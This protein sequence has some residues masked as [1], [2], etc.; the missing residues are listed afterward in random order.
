VPLV[1]GGAGGGFRGAAAGV[2]GCLALALGLLRRRR[3]FSSGRAPGVAP[4]GVPARKRRE[5]RP[6][7]VV[8]IVVVVVIIIVVV[9]VV[10]AKLPRVLPTPA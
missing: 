2:G 7:I 9:T 10:I 5:R 8:V 4:R 3:M 6:V 1:G